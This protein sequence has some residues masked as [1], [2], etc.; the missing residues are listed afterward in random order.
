MGCY[1]ATREGG[2]EYSS[3][4][5]HD[6]GVLCTCPL[7]LRWYAVLGCSGA[8]RAATTFSP[9]LGSRFGSLGP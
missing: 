6:C 8:V 2:I 7:V 1:P 9:A 3:D 4:E 5:V